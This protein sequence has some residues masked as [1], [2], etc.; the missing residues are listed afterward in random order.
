MHFIRSLNTGRMLSALA[1]GGLIAID[2]FFSFTTGM[3]GLA[4]DG[5]PGRIDPHRAV[6]FGRAL[7]V[8]GINRGIRIRVCRRL[9]RYRIQSLRVR[10]RR[11]LSRRRIEWPNVRSSRAI[12]AA[13]QWQRAGVSRVLRAGAGDAW[14][15][16]GRTKARRQRVRSTARVRRQRRNLARRRAGIG[17]ARNRAHLDL[18]HTASCPRRRRIHHGTAHA[19]NR[20]AIIWI[21][22]ACAFCLSQELFYQ[23]Y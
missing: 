16:L 14:S 4:L 5:L 3:L 22:S 9:L 12:S 11:L 10:A 2:S 21:I 7:T 8:L 15:G 6:S 18:L 23:H 19:S 13:W 1:F 20:V 17:S